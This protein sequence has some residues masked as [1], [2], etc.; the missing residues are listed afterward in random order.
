MN[1]SERFKLFNISKEGGVIPIALD[2][3]DLPITIRL[4]QRQQLLLYNS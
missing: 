2:Q 1:R 3:G 4:D